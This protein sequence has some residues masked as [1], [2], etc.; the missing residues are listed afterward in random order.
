VREGSLAHFAATMGYRLAPAIRACRTDGDD[1]IFLDLERDRYLATQ[2]SAQQVLLKRII[3]PAAA[4]DDAL[5]ALVRQGLLL[6]EPG[7]PDQLTFTH[8]Q[9]AAQAA[10]DLETRAGRIR[11][12]DVAEVG[13]IRFQCARRIRRLG[14]K[15][16]EIPFVSPKAESSLR[17]TPALAERLPRLLLARALL[18]APHSCLLDSFML[19]NLLARRRLSS[20]IV[21]GVQATPFKAHCWVEAGGYVLNDDPDMLQRFTPIL[22]A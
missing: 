14:I 15:S 19:R 20:E 18:P 22:V 1:L 12:R 2:G 3:A 5:A 9:V 4:P 7:P 6:F 16:I 10:A 17:I 13:W 8:R 11:A 21:V